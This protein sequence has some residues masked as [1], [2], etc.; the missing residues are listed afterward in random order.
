MQLGDLVR[1]RW[2][3]IEPHEQDSV[4]IYIGDHREKYVNPA[5]TGC[6]AKIVYPGRSYSLYRHNEFEV[7]K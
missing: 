5:F 2:G 7:I 3:K 1:K 6:W 4:G